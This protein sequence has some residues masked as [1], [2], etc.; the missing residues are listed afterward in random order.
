[1]SLASSV[2]DDVA[3]LVSLPNVLSTQTRADVVFTSA[4]KRRIRLAT[5][6]TV[7]FVHSRLLGRNPD[8]RAGGQ[9]NH[10]AALLGGRLPRVMWFPARF[11]WNHAVP[12]SAAVDDP[13]RRAERHRSAAACERFAGPLLQPIRT[14]AATTR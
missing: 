5:T 14:F 13:Q 1:M 2:A 11:T 10:G 6:N 8:G 9:R 7:T 3:A 4:L 12:R